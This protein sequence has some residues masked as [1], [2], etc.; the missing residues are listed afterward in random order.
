MENNQISKFTDIAQKLD[1][2]VLSVIGS[3]RIQGFQ[4]AYLVAEA[5]S[6]L[7]ELL[8]TEYMKPIMA[9]QG[10]RL[11]FKSDKDLQKS[12]TGG[13]VK[14]PGYPESV[15]K[16]CLIEAVL[17]GLQPVNNQFNIIGGNMY[18]T[19]EGCGYL[20]NNLKGLFYN[21]VCSIQ[22]ISADKTSAVVDVKINWSINGEKNEQTIPIPIK[23][24][25]Y[26]SVDA[27][28][29]KAT[30]K[31]RAWLLSRVSGMEITD[32]EIED[33]NFKEVKITPLEIDEAKAIQNC[34]TFINQ[35]KSIEQLDQC[36]VDSETFG[37]MIE[38]DMKYQEIQNSLTK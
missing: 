9:L 24:D 35:A 10:N 5:I 15:V 12:S 36:K 26:T 19:K 34:E 8:T 21:L 27:L 25:A 32:G 7:T 17:M 6:Q 18:P 11:G 16:N 33:V 38:W 22:K 4:K 1:S 31:G 14:G 30:R 28:I 29:G 13:Y 3:E 2:N 37:L 20:L 23:M